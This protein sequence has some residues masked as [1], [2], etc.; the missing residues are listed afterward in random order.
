MRQLAPGSLRTGWHT[1]CSVQGEAD[2]EGEGEWVKEGGDW[3]G[4]KP[5]FSLSQPCDL[6]N[7]LC[8]V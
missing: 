8:L 6:R 2:W 3:L 7:E 1:K 4:P 5:C